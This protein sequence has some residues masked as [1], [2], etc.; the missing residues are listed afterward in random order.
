[1][2]KPIDS[3]SLEEIEIQV[4]I[5]RNTITVTEACINAPSV[6]VA[7]DIGE[8]RIQLQFLEARREWLIAEGIRTES[9]E[10]EKHADLLARA[11]NVSEHDLPELL[12]VVEQLN[13]GQNKTRLV[14][15]IL[16]TLLALDLD[17]LTNIDTEIQSVQARIS[18]IHDYPTIY[19]NSLDTNKSKLEE[20]HKKL[21][22]LR[23]NIS[24]LVAKQMNVVDPHPVIPINTIIEAVCLN[25]SQTEQLLAYARGITSNQIAQH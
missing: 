13:Q 16:K 25:E 15:K 1:M 20:L 18:Y 3:M 11:S 8:C 21:D 10:R 17:T 22:G 4:S 24:E 14:R 7:D 19:P 6:Y 12:V 5:Y 2:S 9:F 23:A